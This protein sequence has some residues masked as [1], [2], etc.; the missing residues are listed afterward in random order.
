MNP[1]LTIS[2]S[3]PARPER[4]ALLE[5][6]SIPRVVIKTMP[7]SGGLNRR[8]NVSVTPTSLPFVMG[9][10]IGEPVPAGAGPR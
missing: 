2:A 6:D 5:Q 9:T 10:V 1:A 4:N 3:M 8:I 7:W